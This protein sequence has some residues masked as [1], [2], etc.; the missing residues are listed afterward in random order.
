MNFGVNFH[1]FIIFFKTQKIKYKYI[2]SLMFE[3]YILMNHMEWGAITR[4]LLDPTITSLSVW[5]YFILLKTM[6]SL[7]MSKIAKFCQKNTTSFRG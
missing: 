7:T 3:H 5:F 4:L 2:K 1:E 6:I